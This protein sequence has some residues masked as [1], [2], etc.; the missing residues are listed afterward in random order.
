M[1]SREIFFLPVGDWQRFCDYH[2]PQASVEQGAMLLLHPFA[3]EMSKLRRMALQQAVPVTKRI[4][5]EGRH[6]TC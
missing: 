2:P 6:A 3:E 4:S 1:S 5:T